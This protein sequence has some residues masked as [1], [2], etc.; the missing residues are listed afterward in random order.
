MARLTNGSLVAGDQVTVEMHQQPGDRTCANEAIGG[1]HYGPVI[2]YMA[3]VAD[4]ATLAINSML[5]S[6][7]R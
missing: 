7:F 5:Q 3:K 1:A 6:L 4:A 2:I